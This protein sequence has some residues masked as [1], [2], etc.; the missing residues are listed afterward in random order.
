MPKKKKTLGQKMIQAKVLLANVQKEPFKS[1]LKKY[2]YNEARINEGQALYDEAEVLVKAKDKAYAAQ[3]KATRALKRKAKVA[4]DYFTEQAI[5][6][7]LT[8]DNDRDSFRGLGISG[9][10]KTRFDAWTEDAQSFYNVALADPDIM[11]ALG[12]NGVTASILKTGLALIEELDGFHSTQKNKIGLAQ[13]ATETRNKKTKELFKWISD[14][15]SFSRLAFKDNPQQLERFMVPVYS[16]GYSPKKEEKEKLRNE[17]GK[18]KEKKKKIK[19]AAEK[20]TRLETSDPKNNLLEFF[21][22]RWKKADGIK[23]VI[24]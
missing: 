8:L 23:R 3:K 2:G 5:I 22:K 14:I 12:K 19:I 9:R 6:A 21:P 18:K 20:G 13:V 16:Q 10:K 15:I 7:R 1:A 11:T 24:A 4:G 17:V